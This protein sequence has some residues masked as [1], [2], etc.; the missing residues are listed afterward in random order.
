MVTKFKLADPDEVEINRISPNIETLF[1]FVQSM[2]PVNLSPEKQAMAAV[3]IAYELGKSGMNGYHEGM[4]DR[5]RK[6]G[7]DERGSQQQEEAAKWHKVVRPIWRE[8]R[9]QFPTNVR[10]RKISQERLAEQLVAGRHGEIAG[11]PGYWQVLKT[12]KDWEAE[13][14]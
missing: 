6:N 13:S 3:A 1:P 2:V 9:G 11:L 10:R 12:I 5:S 8:K 4:T 14:R 7:G